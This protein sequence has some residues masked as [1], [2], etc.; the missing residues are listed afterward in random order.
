MMRITID[1]AMPYAAEV[2]AWLRAHAIEPS[3][4]REITVDVHAQTL[5]ARLFRRDEH[6]RLVLFGR[7]FAT[8]MITVPLQVPPAQEWCEVDT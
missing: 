3:N 7:T 2:C 5:T 6:D 8:K 4:V 1:S